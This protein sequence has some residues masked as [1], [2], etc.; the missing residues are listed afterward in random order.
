MWYGGCSN[1]S[2]TALRVVPVLGRTVHTAHTPASPGQALHALDL[3][4]LGRGGLV[5]LIWPVNQMNLKP[6]V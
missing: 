4:L 3:A 1:W 2:G 6:L 5:N